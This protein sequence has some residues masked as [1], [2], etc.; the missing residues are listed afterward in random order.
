[1]KTIKTQIGGRC[2]VTRE[3]PRDIRYCRSFL[4]AHNGTILDQDGPWGNL[5]AKEKHAEMVKRNT[6][7]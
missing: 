2:V 5:M 6:S 1:M 7:F 3:D 4:I